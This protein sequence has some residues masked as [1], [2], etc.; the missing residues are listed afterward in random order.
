[1][2]THGSVIAT[3]TGGNQE[4]LTYTEN[5]KEGTN[6]LYSNQNHGGFGRA[7]MSL[8]TEETYSTRVKVIEN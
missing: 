4:D 1:M 6:T 8:E 5:G 7:G 3:A 2:S